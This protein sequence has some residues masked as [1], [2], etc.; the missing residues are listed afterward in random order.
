MVVDCTGDADV[1]FRAEDEEFDFHPNFDRFSRDARRWVPVLWSS[2]AMVHG[3]GGQLHHSADYN[4]V[5][6]EFWHDTPSFA[7]LP[8]A[9]DEIDRRL[10]EYK[11][12]GSDAGFVDWLAETLGATEVSFGDVLE[13]AV[14]PFEHAP[15]LQ[16]NDRVN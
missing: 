8:M 14:D 10:D 9:R 5:V 16:N 3:G 1:A 13:Y 4:A 15:A 11:Q 7:W 6:A 2:G 12:S